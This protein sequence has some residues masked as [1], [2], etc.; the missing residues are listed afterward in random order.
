MSQHP[1]QGIWAILLWI[2]WHAYVKWWPQVI[3]DHGFYAMS[4]IIFIQLLLLCSKT[5]YRLGIR[6]VCQHLFGRIFS[7]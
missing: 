3:R 4:I 1:R 5:K 7:N 2:S 6:M